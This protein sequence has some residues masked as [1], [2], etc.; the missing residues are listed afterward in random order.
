MSERDDGTQASV[1]GTPHE[2]A[3]VTVQLRRE[4]QEAQALEAE[5]N[6]RA[7]ALGTA[8]KTV[9]DTLAHV[10][11]QQARLTEQRD[12]SAAEVERLSEALRRSER[13]QRLLVNRAARLERLTNSRT[14]RLAQLSWRARARLRTK[15]RTD[16][17]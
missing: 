2:T 12:A 10:A 16:S 1:S 8:H 13:E 7:V 9:L 11:A 17:A 15:R 5:A 6:A 14:Y 3:A 4:L